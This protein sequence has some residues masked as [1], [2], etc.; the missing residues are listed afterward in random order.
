MIGYSFLSSCRTEIAKD[1]EDRAICYHSATELA[2]TRPEKSP[3]ESDTYVRRFRLSFGGENWL[4]IMNSTCQRRD[5]FGPR[6]LNFLRDQEIEPLSLRS[7][8]IQ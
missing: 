1:A 5:G 2:G 7:P 6:R 4:L 3:R 8:A